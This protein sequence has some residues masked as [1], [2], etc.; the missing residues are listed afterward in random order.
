M[1]TQ[2]QC[3]MALAAMYYI[4]GGDDPLPPPIP[5]DPPIIPGAERADAMV[6]IL[7]QHIGDVQWGGFVAVIQNWFYGYVSQTNWC[8]TTVS[9]LLNQVSIN[10]KNA[11]V[12]GLMNDLAASGEGVLYT[13]ENIPDQLV[14]GDICFWLWDGTV[15][16]YNSNK[17]VNLV[18]TAAS[19]STINAIG[20]NQS[21]S[22]KVSSYDRSKLYAVYRLN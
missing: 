9:Y 20:G 11:N 10:I 22:I 2:R 1:I 7:A 13:K 15:M 3:F 18:Y 17:H 8:A 5:P 6:D 14:K 19:G 12:Y 4:Q 21:K 16:G